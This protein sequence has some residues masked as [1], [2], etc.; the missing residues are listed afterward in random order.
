MNRSLIAD[1]PFEGIVRLL[2][3][4]I[5]HRGCILRLGEA[6]PIGKIDRVVGGDYFRIAIQRKCALQVLPCNK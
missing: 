5:P 2:R 4:N 6:S 3:S 1:D